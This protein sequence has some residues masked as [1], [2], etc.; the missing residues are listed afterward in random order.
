MKKIISTLLIIVVSIT[1]VGCSQNNNNEEIES[2]K[3]EIDGL[4]SANNN[5]MNQTKKVDLKLSGDFT[6]TVQK[7]VAEDQ[8]NIKNLALV[9]FFQSSV[10]LLPVGE[11]IAKELKEGEVYTFKLVDS[12]IK[13]YSSQ[14][15]K[16]GYYHI[17]SF[18]N[19][20]S[21][22]L[23]LVGVAKESEMGLN[24]NRIIVEEK[25]E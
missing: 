16:N 12:T 9:N 13:N 22:K 17:E 5:L 14:D 20:D 7:I 21:V 3:R 6:V 8:T 25:S 23:E 10:F 1:M 4:K 19:E 11:K 15:F 2:L 24:S 18:L